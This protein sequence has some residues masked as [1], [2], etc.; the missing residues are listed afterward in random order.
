[1]SIECPKCHSKNPGTKPFCGDCGAP[2]TPSPLPGVSRTKSL[3]T[4]AKELSRGTVFAGRYEIIESLGSGGMGRVFRVEDTKAK[5]EVALKLIHP[6]VAAIPR[7]IERFRNE[8]TLARKI[9]H[10]NVCGMYDLGEDSGTHF[11]TM[12]YVAGEDL[13]G[14]IR[15]FGRLPIAKALAVAIQVC[16]G[17]AEAHALGIIHRDLKPGNIMIDRAGN[18]RIMDFGIARSSREKGITGEGALV[19]TP[20]YMSPEQAEAAEVDRRSDLYSLGVLLFEM[21]TGRVPFEAETALGVAM[22]HKSEKPPNPKTFNPEVPDDLAA[23]IL[24]CLEKDRS[25]RYQ[26]AEELLE[27][28]RGIEKGIPET[29]RAAA[30]RPLTSR[31]ITVTLRL[32]RFVIPAAAFLG[33]ALVGLFL[34]KGLPGQKDEGSLPAGPRG[35]AT[36]GPS[37]ARPSGTWA[38][39]IAVMPLADLSPQRDQAHFC[40]GMSGD[41]IGQLSMIRDLKVISR[42]SVVAYRDSPKT[43]KEIA[44][45][46]GVAHVLEGTVQREGET[47]R[48]NV[49]LIDAESGFQI[50]AAKYDRKIAGYFE[51]QDEISQAIA[52]ALKLELSAEARAAEEAGRPD[53]MAL[54]ETYLQGMYFVSSKYVLTY[55]DEDFV[56]AARK[57]EEAKAMAPDYAQTYLGLAWAYWHRYQI[58]DSPADL[59]QMDAHIETAYR[60]RPD[61]AE[62]NMAQGFSHFLAGDFDRAFEKYR[63]ALERGPNRY[64][65]QMGVGYLYQR[66]GLS[67]QA[68][69]FMMRVNELAPFYLFGKYNMAFIYQDLGEFDRAEP[70]LREALA[71]NPRNPFS[72]VNLAGHL[73]RVGKIDEAARL[74][75]ELERTAP[76]FLLLPRYKA[77]LHARR[78]EKAQ[79]LELLRSTSVYALLGMRDEAIQSMTKAMSE[80]TFFPYLKLINDPFYKNLRSDPR[81]QKIVAQAKRKHE[82]WLKKY[83]DPQFLWR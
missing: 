82:E 41:I 77:Y 46:L 75:V 24:R 81:F 63:L 51:I 54:Y 25:R 57:L 47:I 56:Q 59:A 68:V 10:K 79:A 2:L 49:Q 33:L 70:L 71:L 37:D 14:A 62:S 58:T 23:L 36:G 20:E 9:R 74:L 45:E 69:P 50:W 26:T 64:E 7:T 55:R 8:L 6:E 48:I 40:D 22:K 44:R 1:M 16:E 11:I 39:S 38:G 83:G 76:D 18:A 53:D 61:L 43:V 80:G 13:K 78:G 60:L 5:E 73:L 35:A 30:R 27:A 65:I 3:E 15:R 42:S 34:W 28:L 17:L 21:A 31:E 67:E 52:G 66:M 4:P 32:R 29:E 72:L 12:E 19:G